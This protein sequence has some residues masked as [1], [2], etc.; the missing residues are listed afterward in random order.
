MEWCCSGSIQLV[1][2]QAHTTS[3]QHSGR[4]LRAFVC[5]DSQESVLGPLIFLLYTADPDLLLLTPCFWPSVVISITSLRR[6]HANRLRHCCSRTTSLTVTVLYYDD[7]WTTSNGADSSWTLQRP[8]SSGLPLAS[9]A[10]YE[11]VAIFDQNLVSSPQ[12]C[13][14]EIQAIVTLE[15]TLCLKKFT[16]LPFAITKS[17]VDRFSFWNLK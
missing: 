12:W 7:N 8:I 3:T 15:Y 9:N 2:R 14:I 1:T 6:R 4:H 16:L 10:G 5:C 11:T 17:D 13:K